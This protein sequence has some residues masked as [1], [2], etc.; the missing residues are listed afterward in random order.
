ML[1]LGSL[2]LVRGNPQVRSAQLVHGAL[3]GTFASAEAAAGSR[4]RR[5]A[6]G[7]LQPAGRECKCLGVVL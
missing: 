2:T 6:Y 7:S 5:I 4:A 3:P 1:L